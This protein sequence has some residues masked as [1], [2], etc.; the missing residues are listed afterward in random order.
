MPVGSQPAT[1]I[2]A[3]DA[4]TF[5]VDTANGSNTITLNGQAGDTVQGQVNE[6]N[7]QLNV[8][9]ITASL[10]QSG[11]LQFQSSNTFTVKATTT[12]PGNDLIDNAGDTIANTGL[13]N[14][15]IN[16][17]TSGDTL[18]L[19]WVRPLPTTP[20]PPRALRLR[21][22]SPASTKRC[23][24]KASR[25]SPRFSMRRVTAPLPASAFKAPA[26]SACLPAAWATALWT[27]GSTPE[28]PVAILMPPLTPSP[29]RQSLGSVQGIVGAGENTLNYAINLA[30]SQITS[31]SSAQSQI[32]D[33]N[34]GAEAADLTKAQVLPQSSIAA[35]AQANQEP[36]AILSLLKQ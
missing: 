31:F 17:L 27:R 18:S 33:A 21:A 5:I 35:M 2:G 32:R 36:Q 7:A 26:A 20:S 16:T 14:E 22:R 15:A 4:D 9:G 8:L 19:R 12:S 6:L 34:V 24:R 13:N 28:Q 25:V 1:A 23:K 3:G 11:A 29:R 10:N 30:Q